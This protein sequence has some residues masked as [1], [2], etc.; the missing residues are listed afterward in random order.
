MVKA[1]L[2]EVSAIERETLSPW[3]AESIAQE[4]EIAEAIQIV[5]EA[6][7]GQI[8][9]WCACRIICPEAELLKIAVKEID[10][11]R[12]IGCLL[13]ENLVDALQK[14]EISSLFLEVRS[15]NGIALKFYDKHK[16]LHVG[17]RPGYY[18]DPPDR[19]M[20]LKKNLSS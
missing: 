14:K 17:S 3:S 4:L 5:A 9:G 1:D 6:P 16:F 8:M 2:G 7:D 13:V 19:A 18:T 20:I 11:Q 12:G 10:R 15:S